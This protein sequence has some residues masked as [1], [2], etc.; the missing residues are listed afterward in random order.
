MGCL[1]SLKQWCHTFKQVVMRRHILIISKQCGRLRRRKQWNHP[2]TCPQPVQ[3]S[4]RQWA[5]FLCRSSK[6]VSQPWPL[7]H[8][9][10]T[11]RKRALKGGM[12]WQWRSRWYQSVT[13]EFIVCLARAVKDTHQEE[14]HCYHCSSP[15]HFICDCP[16][17]A[18]S[19]TD[20]HLNQKEGMAPKKGA[21][22]PQGK[23]AILK[24]P[25]DR[26]PKA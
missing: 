12:H 9:W 21:Q 15:D 5:S 10:H 11:W 16:L 1:N 26:T 25:Q 23:V 19:R 2:T 4:P 13:E 14:K 6:A 20:S 22:A 3:I 7:L 8:G 18:G 17:V 24:V